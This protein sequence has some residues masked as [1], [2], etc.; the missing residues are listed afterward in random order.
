MKVLWLSNETPDPGGQGGQRRQYFLIR[1]VLAAGH[2]IQVCTLEGDQDHREIAALTRVFRTRP[3]W[4]GRVPRLRHQLLLRN[5]S[6]RPWDAVVVAHT[7]SWPT[8]GATAVAS[9]SRVWAD[10]HNVL[11]VNDQG[12]QSE[13]YEV[14]KAICRSV[15]VVSVC[16]D[17]ERDRLRAQ[18]GST[19]ARIEVMPHGVDPQEWRA[20]RAPSSQPVVKMFGNW[21]WAPNTR[22]ITWFLTQVWPFL[23]VPKARLEIAGSG[24]E[25]VELPVG[26]SF[27]GRVPRLDAWVSDAWAVAVP[28][29]GG[30]GAPVK[31]LEALASRAPVLAT[32]DGAPAARDHA[33]IVSEEA[34]VWIDA[35]RLLLQPRMAPMTTSV[36]TDDFSWK[37]A[38]TPLVHWLATD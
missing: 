15:D 34:V 13:W 26:A 18:Q 27:V 25:G 17:Q 36:N 20:T 16:S 30:I 38:A 19:A 24:L 2:A 10:L 6:R 9:S 4:R 11:G 1:E 37:R 33:H 35:L 23:D 3:R 32:P 8:F 28:V 5:L 21:A 12:D 22:G 7:E 29:V 31:Y 14:E